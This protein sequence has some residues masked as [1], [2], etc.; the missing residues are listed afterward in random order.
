MISTLVKFAYDRADTDDI[1]LKKLAAIIVSGSCCMAGIV[2]AIMYYYIFG[3]GLTTILPAFFVVIVGTA[4]LIS[5]F[6]KNHYWAIY[7]QIIC[8][9][10]ITAFIQWSIGDM[11]D[12]G[13]VL[14]WALVGPITA[15]AFF[16]I[17][18][19]VAW[20]TLYLFN[21][22]IT[23]Y[24]NDYF[25]SHALLVEDSTRHFFFIMNLGVSSL[26]VFVFASYFVANIL[27][28][29]DKSDNLL[30]NILPISIAKRLKLGEKVI[31][32]KHNNVG[33]LFAD[34]CGF[35]EF[36]SSAEPEE[37]IAKLDEIFNSFDKIVT[38]YGL[39]KIKTIGDAY[40]VA[41]GIPEASDNFASNLAKMALD[42]LT[43][44]ESFQL[45]NNVMLSMRIGIHCGSVVAGVIGESKFAYDLWGD[46][47]NVASRMESTGE[48]GKIQV[49][50]D[51]ANQIMHDFNIEERGYVE[52][53]GKGLM[54]TFFLVS[55]KKNS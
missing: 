16:P 38:K 25:A 14:A 36:S 40:M 6:T 8:I 49:S 5:H 9:M 34:I 33:V 37:V 12:S 45:K 11:F 2:W 27:R 53:K 35:T 15:L 43:N 22:F 39:E 3:F 52:I 54:Q 10:Y 17:K 47:V 42:M 41:S 7:A 23:A 24:F 29:R 48:A 18:Q 32:D 28:E 26:V 30:L 19:A 13:F 20:F 55:A 31:A 46:T 21:I 51:F 4:I 44:I 1:R 50:G